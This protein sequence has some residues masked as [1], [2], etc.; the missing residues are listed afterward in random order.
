MFKIILTL[1]AF[2]LTLCTLPAQAQMADWLLEH[3]T[4]SL[5][6]SDKASGG[7]AVKITRE[8]TNRLRLNEAQFLNLLTINRTKLGAQR[9]INHDYK[10]DEKTRTAKM[11][12][13]ESQYERE[14]SRI[15]TPSQLSQLQRDNERSTTAPGESGQGLG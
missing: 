12:E 2:F 4:F 1:S 9:S 15:L 6:S 5:A 13:L 3:P 14:C 7:D 10:N 11:E 8:M